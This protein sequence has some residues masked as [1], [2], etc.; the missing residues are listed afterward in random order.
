MDSRI[1]NKL[2]EAN[3]QRKR[4]FVIV[5]RQLAVIDR[6]NVFLNATKRMFAIVDR[7]LVVIDRQ[8]IFLNARNNLIVGNPSS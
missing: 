7:Q 3:I 6:Q 4:M 5:D 8:N 2:E 1:I